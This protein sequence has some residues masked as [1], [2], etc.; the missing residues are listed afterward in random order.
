[1]AAPGCFSNKRAS[2]VDRLLHAVGGVFVFIR[3]VTPDIK[4]IGLGKWGRLAQSESL[5]LTFLAR[6]E[7][8]RI[9]RPSQAF[10]FII[11]TLRPYSPRIASA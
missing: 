8:G 11:G 10:N 3:N 1:M 2:V 4:N 7:A 9:R 5:R 6:S